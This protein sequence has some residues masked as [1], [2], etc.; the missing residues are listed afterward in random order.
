MKQ[1]RNIFLTLLLTALVLG[2]CSFPFKDSPDSQAETVESAVE[3]LPEGSVNTAEGV[4]APTNSGQDSQPEAEPVSGANPAAAFDVDRTEDRLAQLVL[5]NEDLP[6]DYRLPTG[7][8]T[9]LATS[10]L[11]NE[12]GEIQAKQYI[13][14]TGRVTGWKI[15]LERIKKEDFAPNTIENSIELFA[16]A[17]GAQLALSETWYPAYRDVRELKWVDGGCNIGDQCIFYYTEKHDPASQLTTLTYEIAFT[18][19]NTLVWVM[20]RGLDIDIAPDYILNTAQTA[21]DKL[22]RYALSQ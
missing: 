21:F 20:G 9:N 22:E 15:A 14:A 12:M 18:D 6:H 3:N 4:E 5:R 13:T 16:T 1:M 10:T 11:I 19:R 8:E 2:A 7:G 17:E